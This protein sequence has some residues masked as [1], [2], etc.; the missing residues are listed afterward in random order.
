LCRQPG[1]PEFTQPSVTP[2]RARLRL[3]NNFKHAAPEF[4]HAPGS[5]RYHAL[6]I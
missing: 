2:W 6:N 5:A 4:T 1:M 3:V